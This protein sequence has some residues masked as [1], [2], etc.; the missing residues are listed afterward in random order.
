MFLH[1]D[2]VVINLVDIVHSTFL[3]NVRH[4]L[5]FEINMLDELAVRSVVFRFLFFFERLGLEN[6][7]AVDFSSLSFR[8]FHADLV[9]FAA[10]SPASFANHPVEFS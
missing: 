8:F 9:N 2:K 3:H 4:V 6:I 1:G 10:E 5:A 7:E